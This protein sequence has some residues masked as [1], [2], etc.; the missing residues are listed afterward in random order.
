MSKRIPWWVFAGG[1]GV[2]LLL[3]PSV[4][5]AASSGPNV[6]A[7][8]DDFI[9]KL[10]RALSVTGLSSDAKATLIGQAAYE[11]GWGKGEGAVYG[12][13]YWNLSASNEWKGPIFSGADQECDPITG[14]VCV[15]ITQAWR[16]YS[17]DQQAAA[18]MISF[19][20]D[21][22]GGR[23]GTAYQYLLSGDAVSYITEL[24]NRGYF[25]AEPSA[26]ASAVASIQQTV[27]SK[28]A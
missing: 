24:R 9:N 23:Y 17:S 22:N 15:P 6:T 26:Y 13:N 10:W 8:P 4:A 18:D 7:D 12:R 3:V 25:T 11:S 5:S 20:R 14:M 28:V 16:K 1:A 27:L 19:L 2:L 21:Q